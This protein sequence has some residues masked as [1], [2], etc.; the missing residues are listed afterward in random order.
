MGDRPAGWSSKGLSSLIP[1]AHHFKITA[2][3]LQNLYTR[4]NMSYDF[5]AHCALEPGVS[6]K[7]LMAG[8]GEKAC[9]LM[10][11]NTQRNFL[12]LN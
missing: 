12:C 1:L 3:F 8:E 2:S 10:N 7:W 11:L 5:A 6:L 9:L 4:G